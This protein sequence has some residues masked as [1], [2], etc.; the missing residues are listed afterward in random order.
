MGMAVITVPPNIY[1]TVVEYG[2]LTPDGGMVLDRAHSW[3]LLFWR[4]PKKYRFL[5]ARSPYYVASYLDS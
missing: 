2:M 5:L 1:D 4:T 3:V